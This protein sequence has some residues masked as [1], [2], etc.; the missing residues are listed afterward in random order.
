MP[1]AKAAYTRQVAKSKISHFLGRIQ[2]AQFKTPHTTP[3]ILHWISERG[4]V[5]KWSWPSDPTT[6]TRIPPSE[7]ESYRRTHH[8][9]SPCCLCAAELDE[10][11]IEA[12]I[13]LVH[14][15]SA[16]HGSFM[17]GEY[18]A[19]CALRRCGYFVPLERFYSLKLLHIKEYMKRAQ[20]LP[21]EQVTYITDFDPRLD[22]K[23]GLHQAL[24]AHSILSRGS[25][26]R[27]AVERPVST[28]RACNTFTRLW[29]KGLE[30][31]S[32][33]QLFIQCAQCRKIMP[34]DVFATVHS[35]VGCRKCQDDTI[36]T[37]DIEDGYE[38]TS[39]DTEIIDAND[40]AAVEV[41][42]GA[43]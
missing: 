22:Q 34:K 15:P 4:D 19:E 3:A 13:G 31:H 41:L 9:L 16:A 42:V 1:I 17:N 23:L 30:E 29:S 33:W 26:Q 38:T 25:R 24:P 11:Y 14:V 7:L 37:P 12:R 32:F 43:T 5:G 40:E 36:G 8:F 18:V 10:D 20:P 6:G 2:A 27:L 21:A 39:G 28:T 35:P